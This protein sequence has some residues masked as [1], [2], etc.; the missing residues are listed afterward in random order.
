MQV[1]LQSSALRRGAAANALAREAAML[2]GI[3]AQV[4]LAYAPSCT[5]EPG[6]TPQTSAPHTCANALLRATAALATQPGSADTLAAVYTARASAP[7]AAAALAALPLQ[8]LQA[9]AAECIPAVAD[10]AHAVAHGMAE[11]AWTPG[12]DAQIRAGVC[13]AHLGLMKAHLLQPPPGLDPADVHRQQQRHAL[14]TLT[15]TVAPSLR[16]CAT[17]HALPLTP[18]QETPAQVLA[19][20]QA[21]LRADA[22]GYAAKTVLRPVRPQ[23]AAIVHDV[24]RAMAGMLAQA[25]LVALVRSLCAA[26]RGAPAGR[27]VPQLLAEARSAQENI[28][29]WA[30]SVAARYPLYPDLLSPLTVALAE[31]R[32]GLQLLCVQVRASFLS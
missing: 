28:G 29:L 3:A 2:C 17:L 13:W 6:S 30:Q 8:P 15:S 22:A 27:P 32:R 18:S 12:A 11:S 25:P 19:A 26:A 9:L 21:R 1:A 16:L 10:L 24:Q 14:H 4:L 5:A 23:Y 7:A 20:T 31:L